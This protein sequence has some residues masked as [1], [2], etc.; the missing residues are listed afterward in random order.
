MMLIAAFAEEFGPINFDWR[1]SNPIGFIPP[2]SFEDTILG[3]I[4][5]VGLL[6]ITLGSV[7]SLIV[8]YRRRAGI[9]EKE[10]IKW[11]LYAAII[12]GAIYAIAVIANLGSDEWGLGFW[13]ELL[14]VISILTLPVAIAIAILRYRLFDIDIIIRKTAVYG[15]LTALLALVYFGSVLLLQTLFGS[16]L[17][18]QSTL[19]LVIST[20]LIALLFSP[21]RRWLQG[22]INRR[23]YRQKYDAQQVLARFAQT[24]RDETD[25]EEL[26]AGLIA[27]LQETLQPQMIGLWT[28]ES[29]R[30]SAES[31]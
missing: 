16:V 10:Q 14:L 26:N 21:L 5:I 13:G 20:L 28:A 17:G 15:I 23:F 8:R 29:G 1:L 3:S 7:A 12:F 19:I 9:V 18:Q 4:W 2:D 22:V 31:E 24:A 25:L 27:V 30:E 11:L 6:A